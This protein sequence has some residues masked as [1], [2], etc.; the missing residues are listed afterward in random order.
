MGVCPGLDDDPH[1]R[2]L[3]GGAHSSSRLAPTTL[4][5]RRGGEP[6]GRCLP[7][8]QVDQAPP[9]PGHVAHG[10]SSR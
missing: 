2:S 4:P 5:S 6:F 3:A 10:A 1:R 7:A 9:S 8:S